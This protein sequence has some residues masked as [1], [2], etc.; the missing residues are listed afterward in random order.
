MLILGLAVAKMHQGNFEEAEVHL[1]EALNKVQ[2]PLPLTPQFLS[3]LVSY[4]WMYSCWLWRCS[5][6]P[7]NADCLAN[8]IAV[9]HHLG[10]PGEVIGRYVR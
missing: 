3:R 4:I 5:Q 1:Q 8:M 6:D 2:C 7:S 9:A 10:R